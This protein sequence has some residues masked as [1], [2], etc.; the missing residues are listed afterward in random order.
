MADD[1][2]AK[3]RS[4]APTPARAAAKEGSDRGGGLPSYLAFDAKDRTK[5]LQIR[6]VMA[7]F[8]IPAYSHLLTI[9][10][11]GWHGT[12]LGLIYSFQIV[13]I[14]GRNLQPITDAIEKE[15]C[16]FIQDYDPRFFAP[17]QP[18]Q[19]LIEAIEIVM[20]DGL[21]DKE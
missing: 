16:S 8:N 4:T 13:K 2:L 7:A 10:P 12:E 9:I 15:K 11:D 14:K 21:G 17:P 19:P 20:K 6:R 1:P 18:D 5:R 3:F